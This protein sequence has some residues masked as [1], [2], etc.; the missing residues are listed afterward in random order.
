[1]LKFSTEDTELL[2]K[3]IKEADNFIKEENTD[4]LFEAIEDVIVLQ[5]LNKDGFYNELGQR[6]Q[7]IHDELVYQI[8]RSKA[9]RAQNN[10]E[11]P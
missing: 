1:M 11:T 3:Y 7:D 5:G 6:M 10:K 2:L 4:A 9:R 8:R